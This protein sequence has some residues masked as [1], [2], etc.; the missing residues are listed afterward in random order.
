M[1]N[2]ILTA[3]EIKEGNLLIAN[4]DER[5]IVLDASEINYHLDFSKIMSVVEKITK[6]KIN[7]YTPFIN[8]TNF[9]CKIEVDNLLF[10]GIHGSYLITDI[11]AMV[12]NFLEWYYTEYD[13]TFNWEKFTAKMDN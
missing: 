3:K 5:K 12:V 11:W 6:L 4:F 9:G 2:G 1:E 8:I 13:T 7:G 10:C